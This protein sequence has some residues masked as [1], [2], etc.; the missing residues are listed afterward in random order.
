MV[1]VETRLD[2][3]GTRMDRLDGR[4]DRLEG[5]M[6]RLESRLGSLEQ[7][8]AEIGGKLDVLASHVVAKLPSWWQ[9]PAVIAGTV[10][11]LGAL[12]SGAQKLHVLGF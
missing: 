10:V 6:E 7:K 8:V 11:L 12:V 1:A 2:V 4:M 5:R 9:M 3:L